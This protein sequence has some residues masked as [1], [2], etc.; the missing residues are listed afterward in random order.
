MRMMNKTFPK[1]KQL[2]V[3]RYP[4]KLYYQSVKKLQEKTKSMIPGSN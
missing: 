4:D 2:V 3:Q 1:F